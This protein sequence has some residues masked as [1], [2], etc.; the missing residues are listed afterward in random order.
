LEYTSCDILCA[1]EIEN[2]IQ[3]EDPSTVSAVLG[4]PIS[5]SNY[6]AVP[7]P[8]YW[9]LVRSICDKYG[10]LLINDEVITGFGRTGKWFG[11]MHFDSK[12]DIISFAKGITSG[13]IP[14]GGAITTRDIATKFDRD[15]PLANMATWGGNPVSSAGALANIDIIEQE[16]LVENAEEMGKYMIQGLQ[17]Q[18][19][20]S[21]LVGDIRGIGL[22]ICIELVADKAT[23][24]QFKPEQNVPDA[25]VDQ[26]YREG[27]L[28]RVFGTNMVFTPPLCIGKNDIDQIIAACSRIISNI[29][30]KQG[31]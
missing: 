23:K 26:M 17:D 10:V 20:D 1:K 8:E 15:S 13:Y 19:A 5:H 30:K 18:L 25:I 27:L 31:Y 3:F 4:E 24:H 22:M 28:F 9:P 11:C 6:V 21:P 7:P 16:N 14:M 2:V 12:P 29:A